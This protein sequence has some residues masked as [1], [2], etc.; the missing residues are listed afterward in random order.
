MHIKMMCNITTFK[1]VFQHTKAKFNNAK[2]QLFLHQTN[3]IYL[4]VEAQIFRETVCSL[5]RAAAQVDFL[6]QFSSITHV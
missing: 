4:F 3:R 2:P 5:Y 6:I 1:N